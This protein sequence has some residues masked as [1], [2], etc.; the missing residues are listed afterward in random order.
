MGLS[1]FDQF[2]QLKSR[3]KKI[4]ELTFF[5][6][7]TT[8][9]TCLPSHNVS[10]DDRTDS[11]PPVNRL[12]ERLPESNWLPKPR[13][14]V[15]PLLVESRS[16]IGELLPYISPEDALLTYCPCIVDTSL[17]SLRSVKDK[18]YPANPRRRDNFTDERC[19]SLQ[20]PLLSERLGVTRSLPSCSLGSF[21]W[22]FFALCHISFC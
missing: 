2:V 1:C 18:P 21:R 10:I 15:P 22:F 7:C 20:E 16:L 19:C 6:S 17:V 4:I 12:E 13:G 3:K 5:L 14:K 9:H 8:H 11:K